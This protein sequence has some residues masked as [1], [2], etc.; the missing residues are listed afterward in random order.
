MN[1]LQKR[2]MIKIRV[3]RNQYGI[4]QGCFH[5]QRI[6]VMLPRTRKNKSI[7]YRFVY[8]CGSDTAALGRN[9]TPLDWAIQHLAGTDAPEQKSLSI[10]TVYIS[11]FEKDHISGVAR[12]VELTNVK[13]I[14]LPYL[15]KDL[16]AC[17]IA[18][19]IAIGT[20]STLDEPTRNYFEILKTVVDGGNVL[21]IPTTRIRPADPGSIETLDNGDAT[22]EFPEVDLSPSWKITQSIPVG[23]VWMSNKTRKIT[24]NDKSGKTYNFWELRVWTYEQNSATTAAVIQELKALKT[25]QGNS[26]LANLLN[27]IIDPSEIDW[28]FRNRKEIQNAY[29]KALKSQNIKYANDHNGVSLCLYS[30]PLFPPNLVEWRA[31]LGGAMWRCNSPVTSFYSHVV[32]SWLATGD[33]LLEHKSVWN[34]FQKHFGQRIEKCRT[35]LMPHHGSSRGHNHNPLILHGPN[36]IAV[37]SAGAFNKHG[38]PNR[39]TIESVSDRKCYWVTVSEFT[40]PGFFESLV[41][42]F[43]PANNPKIVALLPGATT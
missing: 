24:I 21:G 30:G 23:G 26:A 17:T 4:G 3:D 31:N 32:T 19:G 8:D 1:G 14:A 16:F 15:S 38:H 6:G 39:E 10:D 7:D 5:A 20:V 35:I 18:K 42:E 12:L 22:G 37:F 25:I 40:R 27:G 29:Y 36:R 41:Y 2:Q 9:P 33:A 28:A 11:H 34:N 43:F 13:E